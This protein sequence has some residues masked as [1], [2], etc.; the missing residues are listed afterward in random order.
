MDSQISPHSLCWLEH[1]PFT[2]ASPDRHRVGTPSIHGD[3]A[4]MVWQGTV[5]P[6]T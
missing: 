6:P 3:A 2:S 4:V 5:T 1:R